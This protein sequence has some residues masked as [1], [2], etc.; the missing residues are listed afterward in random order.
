M[1]SL[2]ATGIAPGPFCV[3]S[4][5]L[6]QAAARGEISADSDWSLLSDVTSDMGLLRVI[7]G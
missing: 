3:V 5:V 6:A 7:D 1:L 2:A 4:T